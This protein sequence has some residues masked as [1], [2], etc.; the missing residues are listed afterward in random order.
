MGCDRIR[1]EKYG[2]FFCPD[3]HGSGRDEDGEGPCQKCAGFGW[4]ISSENPSLTIRR[5][6]C[7]DKRGKVSP[8]EFL[9]IS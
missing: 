8:S 9:P 7:R 2:M 4:L 6:P 3:C 5:A 1:P